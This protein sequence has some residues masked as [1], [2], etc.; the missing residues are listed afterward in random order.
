MTVIKQDEAPRFT[1]DG[2]TVTAYAAPS[3]GA[4][5]TSVWRVELA[6]GSAS[7]LHSLSREEVFMALAGRAVATID[8]VEHAVAPGD[9]LIVPAE[10]PFAIAADG[11]EP[12][13][14]LVCMPAGGRATVL[15]DGPA[16]VPPWAE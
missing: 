5:D 12:F 8:G 10:R 11:D 15:P 7:P 16:F 6:A 4:A 14:A 9:C 3:R 1:A 13:R 2:T